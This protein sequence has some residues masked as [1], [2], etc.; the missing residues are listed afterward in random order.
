[1]RKQKKL[2]KI[3]DH[4]LSILPN[5]DIP[6]QHGMIVRLPSWENW[7]SKRVKRKIERESN[8]SL[9]QSNICRNEYVRWTIC[10]ISKPMAII[11]KIQSKDTCYG[12]TL[13]N[14]KLSSWQTEK[15]G[16]CT[17]SF[18]YGYI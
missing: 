1:M 7:Y 13:Q 5:P 12:S 2:F 10:Q 3:R 16:K 6:Q 8:L 11:Q 9:T 17:N 18:N 4:L 14:D 15:F